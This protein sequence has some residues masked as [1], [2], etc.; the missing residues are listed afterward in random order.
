METQQ[1]F[2]VEDG[3][4]IPTSPLQFSFSP[5]SVNLACTLNAKWH[6]RFP[7]IEWSNVV[8]NRDY[9]CFVAK[10]EGLFFATAIWSSPI[11]A[12]RLKYGRQMLELRRMAIADDCPANT[13][14]RMLGY[15]RKWIKKEMPHIAILI[16]YQD[17][18]AHAGTIYKAS[19]WSVASEQKRHA[20]WDTDKRDRSA[21]QSTAPKIRWEYRLREP[22]DTDHQDRNN[23]TTTLFDTEG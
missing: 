8:R 13:A 15:M 22:I 12:N 5:C 6:S 20:S 23:Q 19:G 14:S 7:I 4:S 18:E 1:L 17:T 21:A 2:Q 9:V 11:A 3:G 16:S 10:F